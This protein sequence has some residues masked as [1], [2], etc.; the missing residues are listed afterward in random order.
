MFISDLERF[1]SP[2]CAC[3]STI[4]ERGPSVGLNA[5]DS[6]SGV[7]LPLFAFFSTSRSTRFSMS[8]LR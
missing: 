6:G 3:F 2:P 4:G 5:V 7:V 8:H 1:L